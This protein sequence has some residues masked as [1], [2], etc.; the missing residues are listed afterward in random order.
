MDKKAVNRSEIPQKSTTLKNFIIKNTVFLKSKGIFFSENEL[1]YVPKSYHKTGRIISF[2]LNE[3]IYYKKNEIGKIFYFMYPDIETVIL[4]SG[5]SGPFRTPNSEVVF[6]LNESPHTEC[7]H[8]ENGCIFYFDALNLMF[9]KGNLEEKR[10]MAKLGKDEFVVDMF[11]GI[12]YF[13]IPMAVHSKPEKIIAIEKNP[14]SF[15]YLEKNIEI[16]KVSEIIFPVRGDCMI[17]TPKCVADRVLMG[18]VNTTHHYLFSAISALKDTG[19]TIHYH[20]TCPVGLFPKRPIER[21]ENAARILNKKVIIKDA[22]VIKKYSP[23]ILHIVVDAF[24][25]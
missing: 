20:E 25:F 3:N 5:I 13:S 1:Q 10:R 19:G 15:K 14:Y 7:F 23:G 6:S 16:N 17:S 11:S 9:S 2:S 4:T 21:I 24:V 8:K 22:A 18:F 12:G